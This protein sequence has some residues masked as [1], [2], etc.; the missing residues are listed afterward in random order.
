[1]TGFIFDCMGEKHEAHPE[2]AGLL[3]L[4]ARFH[5]EQEMRRERNA[6]GNMALGFS[7]AEWVLHFIAQRYIHGVAV[8]EARVILNAERI[9]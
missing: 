5:C 3:L 9:G 6:G 7:E 8:A 1:M 4:H 2:G